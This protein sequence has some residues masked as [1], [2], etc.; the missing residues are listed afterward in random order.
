MVVP[1]ASSCARL[2]CGGRHRVRDDSR[3]G[4]VTRGVHARSGD[5]DRGRSS[6]RRARLAR[7]DRAA[8]PGA[9]QAP[10]AW[11]AVGAHRAAEGR[12]LANG[13]ACRQGCSRAMLGAGATAVAA[14][15]RC[16]LG[17]R[18]A[19][20]VATD[21]VADRHLAHEAVAHAL[22]RR[23]ARAALAGGHRRAGN[24]NAGRRLRRAVG[25]A[26]G[27]ALVPWSVGDRADRAQPRAG[28]LRRR[29]RA[30][31]DSRPRGAEPARS[32]RK[33][34]QPRLRAS[35]QQGDRSPC[36]PGRS[37]RASGSAGADPLTRR[38]S[39]GDRYR[40]LPREEAVAERDGD[41]PAGRDGH[42][43]AR[44]CRDHADRLGGAATSSV[45]VQRS[46][47]D[48]PGNARDTVRA[49]VRAGTRN[50]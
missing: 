39:A 49:R 10:R 18:E 26:L 7:S 3:S 31:G 37:R 5:Q 14:E 25:A 16:G 36:A 19:R 20:A 45:T 50:T 8:S 40:P 24:A 47:G 42:G 23:P 2:V 1:W 15:Q 33:R 22:A 44:A 28:H 27:G 13:H 34:P 12:R 46:P 4:A 48:S 9:R 35:V 38:R 21:P 6:H 17:Q 32:A 41:A 29:R 43:P 11:A 30:G